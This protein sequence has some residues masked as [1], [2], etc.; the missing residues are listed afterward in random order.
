MIIKNVNNSTIVT[1]I[2]LNNAMN[3]YLD[4]DLNN[5]LSKLKTIVNAS[6]NQ[7]AVEYFNELESEIKENKIKPHR[8]KSYWASL[9]QVLP[10]IKDMT[11]IA[12]MITQIFQ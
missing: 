7:E 11:D 5:V 3:T 8:V 4:E 1:G 12:R 10:Q 6:G 9:T 2:N